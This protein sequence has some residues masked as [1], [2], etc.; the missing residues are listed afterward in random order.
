MGAVG[1][2]GGAASAAGRCRR[3]CGRCRRCRMSGARSSGRLIEEAH[4]RRSATAPGGWCCSRASRGSARAGWPPTRRTAPTG[5]GSRSCWG[6]CSEELAVPYEPW[7]EVC[8]QL[9]EHAPDGAARSVCRASRRRAQSRLARN[10]ARRCPSCPRRRPPIRRPSGS[11]CSRRWPGWSVRCR[12]SVPVCLVLDDFHWAD[13]QS[14][15]LLKHVART[16]EQ[17]A[18]QLIVTYRDSDLGKDHPLTRACWRICAGSTGVRADRAARSRRRRGGADADRDRPGT[19]STR[20]GVALAGEIAT[21]T[22]GNPFFVGE[23]LR[24]LLES[25]TLLVSTRRR[26]AGASIARRD[27]GC[28]RACAR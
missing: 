9:V 19:S 28:R 1:G 25:G 16:V 27:S 12:R 24:S 13:G 6:A 20:T 7:I 3:C 11:C 8:S 4:G 15:A 26:G 14:V 18:L 17:G 21:E 23:V 10:L 5:R 22:D 2:R